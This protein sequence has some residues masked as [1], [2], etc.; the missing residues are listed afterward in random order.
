MCVCVCVFNR[1]HK[2]T[3]DVRKREMLVRSML[4]VDVP[5][6]EAV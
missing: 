1:G 6:I 4:A 2:T 3:K 5:T